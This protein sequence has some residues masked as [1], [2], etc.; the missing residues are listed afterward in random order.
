MVVPEIIP[1]LT[2]GTWLFF[3]GSPRV[4][5]EGL[6]FAQVL[7]DLAQSDVIEGCLV[8]HIAT[9]KEVCFDRMR[10]W[11]AGIRDTDY[12]ARMAY[13]VENF[14]DRW[15]WYVADTKP[16]FEELESAS[17]LYVPRITVRDDGTR[18]IES[19]HQEI[20]WKAQRAMGIVSEE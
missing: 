17:G 15:E 19:I 3:P 8:I 12:R 6:R 10:R 14:N 7:T 18:S 20:L 16:A 5:Y 11:H 4:P 13:K 2:D 9:P 1:R